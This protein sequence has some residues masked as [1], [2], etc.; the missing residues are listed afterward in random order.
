MSLP[1]VSRS[2]WGAKAWRG[3]VHRVSL[4]EKD[5][6]LIHYHG[7]VPRHSV[8]V[9][10]PREVEAIHLANG[11]MGVGYNFMVDMAGT[12]YEGRGWDGVGSQC[13]GYNRSGVGVYLAVGGT[14]VPTQA[15]LRSAKAIRDELERR[16]GSDVH[17][18]GHR[19]GVSTACPGDWLYKWVHSGMPLAGGGGS[20]API[21]TRPPRVLVPYPGHQHG[22]STKDDHHVEQIQKRLRQLGFY[23]G[24]IDESYG[25]KT[26]AAVRA[27][28]KAKRIKVD[29]W[30]GR[31]TWAA[32]R[33]YNR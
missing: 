32:L 10:V 24:A 14:Q 20:S 29:G 15:A 2:E 19:D 3:T 8:G 4:A 5:D 12:I 17:E 30:V 22:D 26:E 11:W 28:Q 27:F 6:F 25:P 23:K 18:M 31:S 33:I 9:A 1:I 13:P 21:Q 7:G 16:R